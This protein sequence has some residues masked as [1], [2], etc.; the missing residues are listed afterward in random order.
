[1]ARTWARAVNW[2]HCKHARAKWKWLRR[3]YLP[4]WWP[5]EG[6]ATMFD[7]AAVHITHARYRGQIIDVTSWATRSIATPA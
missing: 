1:V 6:D 2:L 7:P 3:R 4:G 5:T